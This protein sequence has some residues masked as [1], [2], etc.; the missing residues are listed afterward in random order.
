M[1]VKI[2][3]IIFHYCEIQLIYIIKVGLKINI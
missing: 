2:V 3:L 1:I